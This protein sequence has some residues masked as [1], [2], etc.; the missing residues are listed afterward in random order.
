M[1][2]RDRI[3]FVGVGLMGHG[4]ARNL[5][6]KG[7]PLTVLAHRSRDRID[8]LRRRGAAEAGSIP[9]LV[10]ASDI[11]IACLPSV[12]AVEA[13]VSAITEVAGPTHIVVDTSTTDPAVTL[14]LGASLAAKGAAYADAALMKGP[15]EAWV[16]ELNVILGADDALAARLSPV[17]SCFARQIFHVGPLG[18]GH[19]VKVLNNAVSMCNLA[20]VAECFTAAAKLGVDR[21]IL[22]EVMQAGNARSR[23]LDALGP[24]L[25]A[26]D[27]S[28]SFSVDV[29]LKDIELFRRMAGD[30]GALTLLG[31]A[32]R[33]VFWL[34]RQTGHGAD[35]SSRIGTALAELSGVAL[36]H[37]GPLAPPADLGP[38][39][40]P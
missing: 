18:H 38:A 31:D 12:A 6:E 8:D 40:P 5:V 32:A 21:R 30:A 24:R 20:T 22:L 36:T 15:Q 7:H 19:R 1:S 27:H 29:G 26:D 25:I 10:A 2:G 34:A 9:E 39:K 28:M 14:R 35:N 17:L 13:V 4:M 23:S 37:D 11:V 16:G 3:G 33:D